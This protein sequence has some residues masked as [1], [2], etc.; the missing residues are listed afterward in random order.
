MKELQGLQVLRTEK[1]NQK[2]VVQAK[3]LIPLRENTIFYYFMN[4]FFFFSFHSQIMY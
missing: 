1:L 2:I 4:D 3:Y